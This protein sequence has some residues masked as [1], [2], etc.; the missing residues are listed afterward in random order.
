M[1][2][3]VSGESSTHSTVYGWCVVWTHGKTLFSLVCQ[4]RLLRLMDR[5]YVGIA[6][7]VG[8]SEIVGRIH[9]APL[10]VIIVFS[11]QDTKHGVEIYLSTHLMKSVHENWWY[12]GWKLPVGWVSW[13]LLVSIALS[14][15]SHAFAPFNLLSIVEH[16]QELMG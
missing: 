10:K 2:E 15:S 8:Q 3:I 4:C 16:L 11:S 5:R 6:K 13:V 7:G 1:V 12:W 14:G 9:V